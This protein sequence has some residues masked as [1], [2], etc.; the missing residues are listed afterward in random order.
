MIA[1]LRKLFIKDPRDRRV[2]GSLCGIVGVC[3]NVLLCAMK[4]LAGG[5]AGSLAIM[6]DGFNNLSDALSSLVSL[7]GFRI[8]G[9]HADKEHPFGHG[10]A[11]YVSALIVAFLILLMG[12]E[13]GKSS[14]EGIFRG[15]E[16]PSFSPLTFW[17][18]LFSMLV[19]LYMGLYN[20]KYGKEIQ[21]SA[22]LATAQDSFFDVLTTAV[23]LVSTGVYVLFKVN[24]DAWCGLIV[25]LVILWGGVRAVSDTCALLLGKPADKELTEKIVAT[26]MGFPGVQGVH[27]LVIHDYGPGRFM[28]TLHAEMDGELRLKEAHTLIDRVEETLEE[29][30]GCIAT[31]H[32]DPVSEKSPEAQEALSRVHA[33]LL[34]LDERCG[35][36]DFHLTY[37]GKILML[38]FDAVVPFSLPLSD[39]E[40]R[41]RLTEG[42]R[43]LDSRYEPRVHIDRTED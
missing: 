42:L 29:T 37:R 6:A 11:E 10:R 36:H 12:A 2:V 25:S 5:I 16:A 15:G 9:K 3:F 26:V 40:V 17:A 39:E 8:A 41:Q 7:V 1:F 28:L 43:I 31:I 20:R 21:S 4:L 13:L 35:V 18:L 30:Y 22:L 14:L 33:L 27:D 24:I 38:T 23:V 32:L 19:K 34:C